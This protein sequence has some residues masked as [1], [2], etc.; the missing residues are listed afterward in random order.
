MYFDVNIV[1]VLNIGSTVSQ[2]L[3]F[4]SEISSTT[5]CGHMSVGMCDFVVCLCVSMYGHAFL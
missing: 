2:L 5:V 1:S 3:H 4:S